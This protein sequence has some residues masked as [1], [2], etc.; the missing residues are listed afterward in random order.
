M[1]CLNLG[2][3][4]LFNGGVRAR[5]EQLAQRHGAEKYIVA[6]DHKQIVGNVWKLFK[7]AQITQHN[8]DI[9]VGSYGDNFGVH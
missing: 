1:N 6:T 8:I 9:D 7:P 3:H 2:I 4:N 5:G